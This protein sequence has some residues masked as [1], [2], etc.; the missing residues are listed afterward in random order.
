METK[1][2]SNTWNPANSS[3][4]TKPWHQGLPCRTLQHGTDFPREKEIHKSGQKENEACL[5]WGALIKS[6]YVASPA[7]PSQ[8]PVFSVPTAPQLSQPWLCL[9]CFSGLFPVL[10]AAQKCLFT[11]LIAHF[12]CPDVPDVISL[13]QSSHHWGAEKAVG[14][15]PATW[16]P[17]EHGAVGYLITKYHR[18]LEMQDLIWKNPLPCCFSPPLQNKTSFRFSPCSTSE[19]GK[20]LVLSTPTGKVLLLIF[21]FSFCVFQSWI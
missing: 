17:P 13:Y 1:P 2:Q 16:I 8:C 6:I 15:S 20:F 18:S 5:S 4:D 10:K 19:L 3:P 21:P 7:A 11:F 12:I 9:E 14:A